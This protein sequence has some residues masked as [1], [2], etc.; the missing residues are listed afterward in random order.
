MLVVWAITIGV[1]VLRYLQ[2][3]PSEIGDSRLARHT[4][5]LQIQTGGS[6]PQSRVMVR[7]IPTAS[8][9][10]DSFPLLTV[11]Q[12]PKINHFHLQTHIDQF[13]A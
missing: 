8:V 2:R 7:P 13:L 10:C 1:Q 3:Q 12:L 6:T 4:R 11:L 9:Q 5:M